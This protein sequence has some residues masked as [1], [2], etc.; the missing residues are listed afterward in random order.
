MVQ[1][2]KKIPKR[3]RAAA[4]LNVPYIF[5][6]A[7]FISMFLRLLVLFVAS[8]IPTCRPAEIINYQ[9]KRKGITHKQKKS[10]TICKATYGVSVLSNV[11]KK[12]YI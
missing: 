3:P 6:S 9:K 11:N 2:F 10:R 8:Q 12:K 1:L 7:I 5:H 4:D